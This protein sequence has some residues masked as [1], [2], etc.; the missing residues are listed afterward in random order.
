MTQYL[1]AGALGL[2][3]FFSALEVVEN[4]YE[5][6]RLFIELQDLH[7]RKD[8]LDQEWSQLLLEQGTWGA[9]GRVEEIARSKLNMTLPTP[10]KIYRV[11]S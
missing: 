8:D 2:G 10:D 11:K 6:R 5:S 3:I 1:I 7:K 4:R 9:H